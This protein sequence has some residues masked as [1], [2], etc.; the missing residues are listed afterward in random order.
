MQV[1]YSDY[2]I[3]VPESSEDHLDVVDELGTACDRM[4]LKINVDKS[5][6]PVE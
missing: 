3:L 6:M 1:M 2:A 4:S 5:E